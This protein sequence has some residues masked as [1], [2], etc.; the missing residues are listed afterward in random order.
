MFF[1][2]SWLI[3]SASCAWLQ[4][5]RR[6]NMMIWSTPP[7]ENYLLTSRNISVHESTEKRFGIMQWKVNFKLRNKTRC[8]K[9]YIS[10]VEGEKTYE[11]DALRS[12]LVHLL[13]EYLSVSY[14]R[15]L[16]C[17]SLKLHILSLIHLIS[18]FRQLFDRLVELPILDLEV[19][20]D[21]S[22]IYYIIF[23]LSSSWVYFM[24]TA[25]LNPIC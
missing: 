16:T 21:T 13:F 9:L 19:N 8:S 1:N 23:Y 25:V 15:K 6:Y 3:L 22:W 10:E 2:N 17:N 24:S 14:D 7:D 12:S 5:E 20:N 11:S 18:T 4:D